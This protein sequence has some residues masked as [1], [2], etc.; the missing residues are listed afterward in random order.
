MFVIIGFVVV[1][2]SVIGGYVMAGGPMAALIQPAEFVIIG[3]A[4]FGSFM[5]SCPQK[6]LKRVTSAVQATM[7]ASPYTQPTYIDLLKMLYGLFSYI[8]KQGL[9]SLEKDILEPEKSP[10]FSKYPSFMNNHHAVAFLTDALSFWLS[11]NAKPHE[12]DNFLENAM[13]THEEEHGIV[14]GLIAKVGDALPGF[15]IVAAVLGIVVTMQHLDGPPEELGHHVAAALVGTFLGILAAYGFVNPIATF[16]E[17]QGK[18]EARYYTMIKVG[19][20][21]FAEGSAP[22]TAVEL[23]RNV[24]F[25]VDRPSSNDLN[26]ELKKK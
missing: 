14:P 12:L 23:A 1:I 18:D 26:A 24:I 13:E 8:R 10:V 9:L 4:S 19:V 7:K 3:G 5:V 21:A 25:S 11:T 2:L 20:I 22:S 15:G 17:I 16:L 6:Y